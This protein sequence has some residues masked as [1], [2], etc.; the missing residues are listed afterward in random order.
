MRESENGSG[1]SMESSGFAAGRLRVKPVE[2]L[3]AG[4]E[5]QQ[6]VKGPDNNQT[7]LSTEYQVHP[8]L[9][10][11]GSGTTGTK[12]EAAQGGAVLT[13]GDGRIYLTERMADDQAG[14]TTSTVLGSE[15]RIGPSSKIY[16]EY[17]WGHGPG[18]DRNVSLMGAKWQ[19]DL[20]KGFRLLL[21][22]EYSGADSQA[23][24]GNRYAISTALS[25]THPSGIRASTRNEVRKE[26]GATK[27]L[28]FL[29]SNHIDWKWTPDFTLLGKFRYSRTRDERLDRTEAEFEERSIGIAY[30]PVRYDRF[31]ALARYTKLR[32]QR[33]VSLAGGEVSDTES[34]VASIEWSWELHRYLEWVTKEAAKFKK[35][36]SGDGPSVKTH[37]YLTIQ[38]L[39]FHL[40]K[41]IDFGAE[42]RILFQEEADDLR[43]GWLTE[44]TWEAIDHLR[45]GVGYN[46]TDFSDNEFSENDYSVHGVFVRMQGKF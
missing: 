8:T 25:Y 15:K 39:N 44:F 42:Y 35:D 43:Q 27:R 18:G 28:Q 30:R 9:A 7:T 31:N 26:T 24:N 13:L 3:T 36:E 32:D 38:R 12:G 41:R 5:H 17:Q 23:Q 45:F 6:T 29:T 14:R 33:P 16:T 37:T 20:A 46:F 11:Q 22:G 21:A 1:D 34:D 19:K 4:L 10:L 40:W 2:K